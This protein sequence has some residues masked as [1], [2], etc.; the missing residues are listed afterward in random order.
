[1]R[2]ARVTDVPTPRIPFPTTPS[3]YIVAPTGGWSPDVPTWELAADQ[4]P[5]LTNFQIK[6]GKLR[7]RPPYKVTCDLTSAA[8]SLA[9]WVPLKHGTSLLTKR[10]F[11]STY[12]IEPQNVHRV[13]V[14]VPSSLTPTD[15]ALYS[16]AG[17]TVTRTALTGGEIGFAPG[18]SQIDFNGVKYAISYASPSGSRLTFND[19]VVGYAT[20]V[21]T[22]TTTTVAG[23]TYA[24]QGGFYIYGW[25]D[26]V[27][28]AGGA[29][30]TTG[31]NPS[32]TA[33]FFSNPL[34]TFT[35]TPADW[36]D[37]VSGLYNQIDVDGNHNDPIVA[38]AS[39]PSGLLILRQ[40]SLF[41]LRGTDPTTYVLR[42]ITKQ[43]GCLDARSVVE[44]DSK[45]YW[46]SEQ[47]F[48]VTDGTQV[49]NV[50]G[51]L[52]DELYRQIATWNNAVFNGT[53]AWCTASKMSDGKIMVSFGIYAAGGGNYQMFGALTAVFDPA[54]GAWVKVS[55]A[56]QPT[57]SNLALGP[58]IQGYGEVKSL[59][60]SVQ[61]TMED[62]VSGL[63]V[64]GASSL[65]DV[66]NVAGTTFA[67][68]QAV[69]TARSPQANLA[70]RGKIQLKR[71]FLDYA[72][73]TGGPTGTLDLQIVD[74]IAPIGS[75]LLL[76]VTIPVSTNAT[77]RRQY[78]QRDIQ[79]ET[80]DMQ[81]NILLIGGVTGGASVPVAEIHGLGVE[82]S[83]TSE[84]RPTV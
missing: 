66:S 48:M 79:S 83:A 62:V 64:T 5:A 59:G 46:M 58:T 76:N 54:T 26:R 63:A 47:G 61:I 32:T 43:A 30:G 7:V 81:I 35:S 55:T 44:L 71:A 10:L 50:S 75:Q 18:W 73:S 3:E 12:S 28:V 38:L 19:G 69:W 74:R 11:T 57:G 17:S 13:G 42:P 21:T 6:P 36:E 80:A 49:Q 1:M 27:W 84:L 24:P 31:L 52:Q 68:I 82:F 14:S 41:I 34:Q 23:I 22:L 33:L 15:D 65:H 77:D 9:G 56:I 51:A 53:G 8:P 72:I 20:A 39:I 29:P 45:V 67:G 40:N 37:P 25:L 4:A 70:S 16:I 60:N 2:G 78:L